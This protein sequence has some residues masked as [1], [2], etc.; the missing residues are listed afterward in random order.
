MYVFS[1]ALS[2]N[3]KQI[4]SNLA[5]EAVRRGSGDNVTVMLVVFGDW[6]KNM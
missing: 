6:Y 5:G 3:C 1:L 4:A 2:F